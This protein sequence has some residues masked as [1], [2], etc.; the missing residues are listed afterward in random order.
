MELVEEVIGLKGL[1]KGSSLAE[2]LR[3]L[4]RQLR[5]GREQ[6]QERRREIGD[7]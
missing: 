3:S 4:E 1:E 5:E 2:R 6:A 7:L